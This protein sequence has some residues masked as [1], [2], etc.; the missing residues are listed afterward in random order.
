MSGPISIPWAKAIADELR[1]VFGADGINAE[2]RKG[3]YCI[4]ENGHV[5]GK[6]APTGNAVSL[7]D[8]VIES[9]FHHK[10]VQRVIRK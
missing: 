1:E 4:S 3:N 8:M 9:N 6:P 7:A 5:L 10:D 2:I